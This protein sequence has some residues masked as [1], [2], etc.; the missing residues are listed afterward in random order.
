MLDTDEILKYL[1]DDESKFIYQ[2]RVE[3]NETGRL[4]VF[5]EIVDRYLPQFKGIYYYP[6]IKSKM[7]SLLRDKKKVV[8]FGGGVKARSLLPFL[9]QNNIMVDSLVD[10]D[11][12]KWGDAK[13]LR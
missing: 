10:N 6:G 3:Y 1:A 12:K 2:K 11:I 4:D 7:I 5:K 8:V 9:R 13:A